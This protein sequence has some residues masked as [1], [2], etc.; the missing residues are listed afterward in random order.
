MAICGCADFLRLNTV[1][2]VLAALNFRLSSSPTSKIFV[3]V[4]SHSLSVSGFRSGTVKLSRVSSAYV[5][6]YDHSEHAACSVALDEVSQGAHCVLGALLFRET[7]LSEAHPASLVQVPYRSLSSDCTATTCSRS[8]VVLYRTQAESFQMQR[9]K[10][11]FASN[12]GRIQ[13]I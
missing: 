7:E 12:H 6:R 8:V 5:E 13:K 9:S 11:K 3:T 2:W 4:L 1:S 10:I